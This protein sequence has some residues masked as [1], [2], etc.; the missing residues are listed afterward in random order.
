MENID[1]NR[2]A[3]FDIHVARRSGALARGRGREF[4]PNRHYGFENYVH[5][6]ASY[7]PIPAHLPGTNPNTPRV[8]HNRTPRQVSGIPGRVGPYGPCFGLET[9]KRILLFWGT[10]N[11]S[12]ALLRSSRAART[13]VA[14]FMR[15]QLQLWTDCVWDLQGVKM[16][17]WLSVGRRRCLR[18]LPNTVSCW[19]DDH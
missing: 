3:G 14:V 18:R 7:H 17:P 13:I 1:I 11:Q 2:R 12:T 6:V 4:L 10:E 19:F 5:A 8:G 16:D 15:S 9:D